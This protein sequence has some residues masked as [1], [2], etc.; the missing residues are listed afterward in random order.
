MPCGDGRK[1]TVS[2]KIEK[3]EFLAVNASESGEKCLFRLVAIG[4]RKL[5]SVGQAA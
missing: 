1:V 3:V 2:E 5:A 4:T